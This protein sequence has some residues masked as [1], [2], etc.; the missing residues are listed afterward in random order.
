MDWF[1]KEKAREWMED[2]VTAELVSSAE[3]GPGYITL[4]VGASEGAIGCFTDT[5]A[6]LG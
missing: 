3:S 5:T 4:G 1:L 2:K 6:I